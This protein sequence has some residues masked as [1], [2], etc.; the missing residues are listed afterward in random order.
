[1]V[2]F[3][4]YSL[5]LK[6]KVHQNIAYTS[7]SFHHQKWVS[8]DSAPSTEV[9]KCTVAAVY[10]RESLAAT[11]RCTCVQSRNSRHTSKS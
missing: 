9:W 2:L 4:L 11:A 5:P 7:T 3:C 1:M 8:Q 10:A 6:V